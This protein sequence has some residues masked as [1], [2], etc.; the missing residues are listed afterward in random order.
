[1]LQTIIQL[2]TIISIAHR[3]SINK[4]VDQIFVMGEG[5]VLE[6]GMHQELLAN[7]GPYVQLVQAQEL[8]EETAAQNDNDNDIAAVSSDVEKF[9]VEKTVT[10]HQD[11]LSL[12]PSGLALEKSE[13]QAFKCI[14]W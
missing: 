8:R 3:F 11:S 9:D 5:A 12:A 13:G 1:M 4:D 10:S 14:C 2:S 7:G 6:H